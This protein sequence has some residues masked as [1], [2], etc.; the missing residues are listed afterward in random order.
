MHRRVKSNFSFLNIFFLCGFTV[1]GYRI[2]LS[3]CVSGHSFRVIEWLY[4]Y[5]DEC[6]N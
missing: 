4:C 1:I 5:H 3:Y 2:L 6:N